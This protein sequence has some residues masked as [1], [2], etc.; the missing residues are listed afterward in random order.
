MQS[1]H[2]PH[3]STSVGTAG[4]SNICIASLRSA[5]ASSQI[6]EL[7][8]LLSKMQECHLPVGL[9]AF[10]QSHEDQPKYR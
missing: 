3:V 9:T 10:T 2:I 4:I 1:V 5:A 6:V 7:R 8:V